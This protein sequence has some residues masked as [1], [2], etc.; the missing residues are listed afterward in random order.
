MADRRH[1]QIAWRV[2][3]FEV[4]ED[5]TGKA[6]NFAVMAQRALGFAGGAA[7]IIEPG[8]I[9]EAG[10]AARRGAA[11]RLDR[12]QEI[13]AIIGR[14]EREDGF[15]IRGLGSELAAAIAELT[16]STTSICA[17]ESCS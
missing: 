16:P 3:N 17:S 14:A 7:G 13:G 5:R 4:G 1:R 15:Q 2:R 11:G 8:D 12:L 10:E 9:V 6:A